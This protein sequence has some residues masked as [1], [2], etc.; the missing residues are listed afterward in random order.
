MAARTD[1][2]SVSRFHNIPN[3]VLADMIGKA[4]AL[5]K[6]ATTELDTL[7]AEAKRRGI[8][9]LAGDEF[10]VSV[11][12]QIQGRPDVAALK[13]HLGDGYARF[14]KPIIS[15]VVRVK[16]VARGALARAA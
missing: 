4:D 14:E 6:A 1:T 16:A 10:E 11:K 5:A 9:T 7:K 13:L 8:E 15:T 3:A 12:D 2:T